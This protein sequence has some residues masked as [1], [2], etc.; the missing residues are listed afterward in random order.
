MDDMSKE[1]IFTIAE[2]LAIIIPLFLLF[3][4]VTLRARESYAKYIAL[5]SVFATFNGLVASLVVMAVGLLFDVDG[6]PLWISTALG[7]IL[8]IEVYQLEINF[9]A[10]RGNRWAKKLRYVYWF[11]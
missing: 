7:V 5:N 4:L 1:D 9:L 8:G 6:Y 11:R 10:N 3:I 2:I